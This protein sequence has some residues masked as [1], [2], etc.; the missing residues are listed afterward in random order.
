MIEHVKIWSLII[1]AHFSCGVRR[2]AGRHQKIANLEYTHVFDRLDIAAYIQY[3]SR[4]M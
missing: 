3:I 2:V 1:I 4:F